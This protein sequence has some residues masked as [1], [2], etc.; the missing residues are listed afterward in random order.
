[1]NDRVRFCP[2]CADFFP[3]DQY[4]SHWAACPARARN[5]SA[6]ESRGGTS[7]MSPRQKS[8]APGRE[9]DLPP[10]SI[11]NPGPS[12]PV[13]GGLAS[14]ALAGAGANS[15]AGDESSS[16]GLIVVRECAEERRF[17]WH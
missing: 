1:M 11:L 3:R 5:K 7:D 13:D 8:T 9:A 10:G 6:V 12:S 16:P 2:E 14:V 15:G 4:S 17:Q